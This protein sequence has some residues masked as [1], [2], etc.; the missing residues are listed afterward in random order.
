MKEKDKKNNEADYNLTEPSVTPA[1]C[2][3]SRGALESVY[4]TNGLVSSDENEI[5]KIYNIEYENTDRIKL[6]VKLG[7]EITKGQII[8][9]MNDEKVLSDC[10]GRI[11]DIITDI[12][13]VIIKILDY[14]KLHINIKVP[15]EVIGVLDY[16]SAVFITCDDV[17]YKGTIEKIGYVYFDDGIDVRISLPEYIMPNREVS[18]RIDLGQT[19]E[20]V[21]VP[22]AFITS[23]ADINYAYVVVPV[24][25]EDVPGKVKNVTNQT[26]VK[27]GRKYTV[28]EDGNIFEYYEVISGINEGQQL[29]SEPLTPEVAEVE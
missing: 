27:L 29:S 26:E 3:V 18:V 21:F 19:K 14:S 22:S 5:L 1:L 13:N 16:A 7:D 4:S 12:N 2:T 8:Y 25:A 15:Y 9:S 20:M 24:E 11:V 6:S 28:Y 17:E 23:I 10:E